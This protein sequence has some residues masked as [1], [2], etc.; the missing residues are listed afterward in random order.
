VTEADVAALGVHRIAIPIPFASAGGPVNVYAIDA[1]DGSL[2]LFDAGLGSQASYASLEAGLA[3]LGRSLADVSRIV[4][5]HGHVDHFGAAR[6]VQERCGDGPPPVFA[7]PGDLPK[8]DETGPTFQELGPR[9]RA[10]LTRHGVPDE[11]CRAV[12]RS[13]ERAHAFARRVKDVQRIEAGQEVVGRS[14]RFEVLHL[15]GHTPGLIALH[16]PARRLLLPA[17]HLLERISPNPLIELGPEGQADWYRP[18]ITYLESL[19][20]TRALELDLV[21]PGHG[22]PFAGHRAVIDGLL[23]FYEKRQ[24]RLRGLLADG[25]R[26]GW[27]LCSALFPSAAAAEAF[28]T[29]SETLANLEVLEARGEVEREAAGD[30][31]RYRS[32]A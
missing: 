4:V 29:M 11:V 5:S 20:R 12:G 16:E 1:P 21:L 15:P 31:W 30:G 13:G 28:L 3:G 2:I 23:G 25:P 24:A 26:S 14:V 17:D 22:P 27:A 7:H 18:L 9:L 32:A 6:H 19:G 10:H 8:I